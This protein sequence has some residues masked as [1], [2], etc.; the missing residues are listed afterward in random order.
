MQ[1]FTERTVAHLLYEVDIIILFHGDGNVFD[2][3]LPD[4]V[5]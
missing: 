4:T 1:F 5:E 3:L 2:P